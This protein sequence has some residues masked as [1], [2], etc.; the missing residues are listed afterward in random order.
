[1]FKKNTVSSSSDRSR[2]EVNDGLKTMKRLS[3]DLE[4][5]EKRIA[6][7]LSQLTESNAKIEQMQKEVCLC[8][9]R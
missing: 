4:Q 6:D 7:L 9:L 1:M 5:K 2:K 8:A 3:L